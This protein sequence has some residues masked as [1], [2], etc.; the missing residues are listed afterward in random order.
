MISNLIWLVTTAM[1]SSV[2][3]SISRSGIRSRRYW[4]LTACLPFLRKAGHINFFCNQVNKWN[5]KASGT[6]LFFLYFNYPRFISGAQLDTIYIGYLFCTLRRTTNDDNGSFTATVL[7]GK[8]F[9]E[10]RLALRKTLWS[11]LFKSIQSFSP[12]ILRFM[13]C[14]Q[15]IIYLRLSFLLLMDPKDSPLY[16]LQP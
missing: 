9:L 16:Q 7:F 1:A 6:T 11:I 3:R 14:V 13:Y 4:F 2:F 12:F 5:F 8:V 10:W 15:M